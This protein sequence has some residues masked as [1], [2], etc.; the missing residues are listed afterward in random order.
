MYRI[1]A[2]IKLKQGKIT[3]LCSYNVPIEFKME[4]SDDF[5]VEIW[6]FELNGLFV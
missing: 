1:H 2:Q 5:E 4:Q 6:D 3:I